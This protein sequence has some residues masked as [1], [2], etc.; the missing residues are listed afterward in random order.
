MVYAPYAP[1]YS[2]V[3]VERS[4]ARISRPILWPWLYELQGADGYKIR[5]KI[6]G[7]YMRRQI[8][9]LSAREH[10]V[11]IIF[12][13]TR[14]EACGIVAKNSCCGAITY[15]RALALIIQDDWP[16][17]LQQPKRAPGTIQGPPDA[18]KA[19]QLPTRL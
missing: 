18:T 2:G 17:R 3:G 10:A 13:I 5:V 19:P 16:L 6:H 8:A 9:R 14:R 15:L 12:V 4:D 7:C 11:A 1:L